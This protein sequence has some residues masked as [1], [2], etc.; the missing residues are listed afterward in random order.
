MSNYQDSDFETLNNEYEIAMENVREWEFGLHDK[1]IKYEQ[2]LIMSMR[3]YLKNIERGFGRFIDEKQF[4]S[5]RKCDK[6]GALFAET[7][8]GFELSK[9]C[10]I[11]APIIF[12]MKACKKTATESQYINKCVA[13]GVDMGFSNPRQF[14][15]KT[16]CGNI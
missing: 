2:Y 14:C 9:K 8:I 3:S 16:Y 10:I 15:R 13:C 7:L 4:E 1:Y 11:L 12:K 5:I 6:S